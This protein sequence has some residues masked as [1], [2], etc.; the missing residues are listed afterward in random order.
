MGASACWLPSCF[1]PAVDRRALLA[2]A[3]VATA[4]VQQQQP[5]EAAQ[6]RFSLFGFDAGNGGVSDAYAQIDADAVSPYSQFSNPKDSDYTKDEQL[7]AKIL[8]KNK[9]RVIEY[10]KELDAIPGYIKTKQAENIKSRLTTKAYQLRDAMEYV[11]TKGSPFYRKNDAPGKKE[12]DIFF[13]DLADLGVAARVRNWEW[14]TESYDK[15]RGS[16]KAWL[17]IVKL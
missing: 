17:D 10:V 1:V 16:F 12:A 14:A 2:A 15:S 11:T 7:Q 13:Q 3:A 4:S 8:A 9:E 5:A 6:A